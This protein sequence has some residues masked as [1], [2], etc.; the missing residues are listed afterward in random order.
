MDRFPPGWAARWP[1]NQ[2]DRG[3]NVTDL[4]HLPKESPHSNRDLWIERRLKYLTQEHQ[5]LG[6]GAIG[7]HYLNCILASYSEFR[8]SGNRRV[9]YQSWVAIKL[10]C[11]W[12]AQ[13]E[14]RA[15]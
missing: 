10:F 2:R 13:L 3:R 6:G 1:G 12:V 9:R 8:A 4:Q 11:Q 5:R 7:S 14:R 15:S